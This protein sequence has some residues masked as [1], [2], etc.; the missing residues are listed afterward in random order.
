MPCST[1]AGPNPGLHLQSDMHAQMS[2][3]PALFTAT[4]LQQVHGSHCNMVGPAQ[5]GVEHYVHGQCRV[6]HC[7]HGYAGACAGPDRELE[8]LPLLSLFCGAPGGVLSTRSSYIA[9][10]TASSDS[11]E[12]TVSPHANCNK[13]LAFRCLSTC[14][15]VYTEGSHKHIA[16]H[17]ELTTLHATKSSGDEHFAGRALSA[18]ACWQG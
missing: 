14:N 11:R 15:S 12:C 3:W 8:A 1:S 6:Q 16:A 17:G 2:S 9:I 13:G 7:M 18:W 5:H 4:L 10:T